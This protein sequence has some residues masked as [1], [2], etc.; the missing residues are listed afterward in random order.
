MWSDPIV[1]EI[2][3]A[4]EKIA[5]ECGFDISRMSDRFRM[6]QDRFRNRVV[7]KKDVVAKKSPSAI[8]G[9]SLPSTGT[10]GQTK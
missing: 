1:E 10:E 6:N 9:Q 4:G 5:A 7:Q 2:R 8:I 3:Q